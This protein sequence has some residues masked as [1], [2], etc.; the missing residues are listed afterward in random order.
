MLLD[1][2]ITFLSG[3]G[4]ELGCVLWTHHSERG[5]PFKTAAWSM[6][7]A[8][9]QVMGIGESVH[10]IRLAPVFV[11]GYGVGTFVGVTWKAKFQTNGRH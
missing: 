5:E 10:D 8:A 1:A 9:C 7:L 4:Y 3:A 6:G 11:V 2:A